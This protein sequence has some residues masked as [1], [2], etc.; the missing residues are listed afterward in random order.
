MTS[1]INQSGFFF[2][3]YTSRADFSFLQLSQDIGYKDLL[4][5]RD[6]Q[7]GYTI[8]LADQ[9]LFLYSSNHRIRSHQ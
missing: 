4:F 9:F 5:H 7:S 8:V 6:H 3:S 1:S 2:L